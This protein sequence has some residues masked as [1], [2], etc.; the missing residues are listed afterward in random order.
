M[1]G[2]QRK[3]D[4]TKSPQWKYLLSNE[5]RRRR[6]ED[7]KEEQIKLKSVSKRKKLRVERKKHTKKGKPIVYSATPHE[8][9]RWM[10]EDYQ[11]GLNERKEELRELHKTT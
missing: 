1:Q 10:N 9:G 7:N 11:K 4:E 5:N 2:H 6:R 3:W 8:K